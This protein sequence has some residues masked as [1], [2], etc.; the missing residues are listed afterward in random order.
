ME[1][2]LRLLHAMVLED[3]ISQQHTMDYSSIIMEKADGVLVVFAQTFRWSFVLQYDK[4][5]RLE[6]HD[7]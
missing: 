7:Q 6:Q 2:A 3:N 1:G 4:D 5:Y